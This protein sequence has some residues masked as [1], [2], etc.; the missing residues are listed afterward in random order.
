VVLDQDLGA[1]KLL[2]IA[3][4]VAATAGAASLSHR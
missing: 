1:R 3:M 4:V 2:A